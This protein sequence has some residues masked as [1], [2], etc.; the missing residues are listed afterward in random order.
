LGR[1]RM[2]LHATDSTM[3]VVV[4]V[5]RPETM[6]LMRRHIDLLAQEFRAMGYADV[7]FEFTGQHGGGEG[8]NENDGPRVANKGTTETETSNEPLRLRLGADAGMD[9]RL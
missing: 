7:G 2:V 1:V 4:A 9:L 5:E 6:E 3:N 8:Q